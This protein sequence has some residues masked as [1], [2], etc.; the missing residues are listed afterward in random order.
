[1]KIV[2]SIFNCLSWV[3][4][5]IIIAGLLV[6]SPIVMGYKPVVVL[7]GSMEPSYH[8]GSVI[9][10]KDTA[11]KDIEKGDAITFKIDGDTLVTH[12]VVEKNDISMTFITKGDANEGNDQNPVNYQNVVGKTMTFSVPY[13]G[14]ILNSPYKI[15]GIVAIGGILVINIALSYVGNGKKEEKEGK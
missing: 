6:L 9:Y 7:S 1:M 14:F 2:K 13:V 15:M 11:F 4:Y 3:C 5:A 10:Y 12:R 8:V